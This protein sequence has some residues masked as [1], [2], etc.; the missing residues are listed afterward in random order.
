MATKAKAKKKAK[1][2]AKKSGA[3][4]ALKPAAKRKTAAASAAPKTPPCG[5]G[6]FCWNE[7]MTSD[8]GGAKA[9]Y[10]GLLGWKPNDMQMPSMTYTIFQRGADQAAGMMQH[11]MPGAPPAWLSYVH[12]ENVDASA[13]KIPGL[14]GKVIVPPQDIPNMGRFVVALDPQG[15]SFALFQPLMA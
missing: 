10:S 14:G 15:A 3:R 7:L 9:F 1:K 5:P 11:P 6:I 13:A 4:K 8:V 2:A 12:V